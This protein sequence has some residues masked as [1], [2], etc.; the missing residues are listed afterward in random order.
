MSASIVSVIRMGR[1]KDGLRNLPIFAITSLAIYFIA[2][3][4]LHAML[5]TFF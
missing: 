5:G 3:S 2:V 4:V 1:V